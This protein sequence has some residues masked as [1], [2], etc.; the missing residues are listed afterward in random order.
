MLILLYIMFHPPVGRFQLELV[1]YFTHFSTVV[2]FNRC[3]FF[4]PV[5]LSS[6]IQY[7]QHVLWVLKI[8]LSSGL[9]FHPTVVFFFLVDF[10][11]LI[12]HFQQ[13]FW[14]AEVSSVSLFEQLTVGVRNLYIGSFCPA[15]SSLSRYLQGGQRKSETYVYLYVYIYIYIYIYLFIYLFICFPSNK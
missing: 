3:V 14:G 4:F 7:F 10:S 9:S 1:C 5:G 8:F 11:S 2:P 12:R 15:M 6:L 13:V